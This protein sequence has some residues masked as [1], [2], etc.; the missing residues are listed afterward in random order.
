MALGLP[1][2]GRIWQGP[3]LKWADLRNNNNNNN[4]A[5]IKCTSLPAVQRCFGEKF[6]FF[7][8]LLE[9]LVSGKLWITSKDFWL[10]VPSY[11]AWPVWL[12]VVISTDYNLSL[13]GSAPGTEQKSWWKL[14]HC[15][16]W[17]Q[18]RMS[19]SMHLER[20]Y[21][22]KKLFNFKP[23][24]YY[25]CV[26]VFV[27]CVLV[28]VEARGRCC[29]PQSYRWLW[30]SLHPRPIWVLGTE[31]RSLQ[32][33]Q[34]LLTTELS[35]QPLIAQVWR[36]EDNSPSCFLWVL[37][38]SSCPQACSAVLLP[39]QSS[40]VLQ[41]HVYSLVTSGTFSVHQSFCII[42]NQISIFVK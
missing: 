35:C 10:F 16:S 12:C 36:S 34:V 27:T 42:W 28:L 9:H 13:K 33:Q 30:V 7:H 4:L 25:L 22:F 19:S 6:F 1:H 23:F 15:V 24:I 20:K 18:I 37:G 3:T 14:L 11:P 29:I 39:S 5:L 26:C 31:P 2:M 41:P 40:H 17:R 38:L 32:Q 8:L 21:F